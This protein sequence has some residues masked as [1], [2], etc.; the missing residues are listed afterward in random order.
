MPG[1][2]GGVFI[3]LEFPITVDPPILPLSGLAKKQR[4]WKSANLEGVIIYIT[5]KK[6][7]PDLKISRRDWGRQSTDGW[8]G[9]W[10]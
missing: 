2:G 10:G 6:H 8:Y 5:K 1:S 7:I 9:G 3:L 4:Y